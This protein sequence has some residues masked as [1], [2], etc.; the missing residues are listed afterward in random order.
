M[1]VFRKGMDDVNRF[2][3]RRKDHN[4]EKNQK[5]T[6][7]GASRATGTGFEEGLDN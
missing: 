3:G 2:G 7:V 4:G 5:L 6:S 1:R